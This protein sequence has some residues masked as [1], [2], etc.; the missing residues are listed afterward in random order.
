MAKPNENEAG[1][2]RLVA[3]E[4]IPRRKLRKLLGTGSEE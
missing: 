3:L 4:R 2:P 1:E